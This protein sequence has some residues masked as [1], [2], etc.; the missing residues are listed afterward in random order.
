MN[1]KNAGWGIIFIAIGVVWLLTNLGYMN[2]WLIIDSLKVL[3]PL[4]LVVIGI[5]TI[6]EKYPIVK[7]IMWLLF[8]AVL[9]G[10]SLYIG[11]SM[12]F[13]PLNQFEGPWVYL[14]KQRIWEQ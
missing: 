3:W 14:I 12:N 6:F 2:G 5:S 1:I 4:I 9:I 10:Y 11:Q 7:L 13:K 8:I